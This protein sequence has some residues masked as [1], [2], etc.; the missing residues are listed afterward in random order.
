[1]AAAPCDDG[2]R[3]HAMTVGTQAANATMFTEF[4][5]DGKLGQLIRA[6]TGLEVCGSKGKSNAVSKLRDTWL[7]EVIGTRLR[8]GP[9]G[10]AQD[11][12]EEQHIQFASFLSTVQALEL[13]YGLGYAESTMFLAGSSP[14]AKQAMCRAFEKLGDDVL[15]GDDQHK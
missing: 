11:S 6:E 8:K 7:D 9:L 14:S 2:C 12:D 15:F 1:M 4:A 5:Q 13:G 3:A 10:S